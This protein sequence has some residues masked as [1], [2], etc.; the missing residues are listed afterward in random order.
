MKQ[1]FITVSQFNALIADIICCEELLKNCLVQGEVSG[2]MVKDNN[3]YFTLKDAKAALS[4]CCFG[5]AGCYIPKNGEKV[6]VQGS[7]DYY[8]KTGRL[9]LIAYNIEPLG[10]GKLHLQLEALKQK[11]KDEGLF[12]A[13][14]KKEIPK[15][16]KTV[17]VVTSAKGAVIQD[18]ISTIRCVNKLIDITV[19]DVKVQGLNAVQSICCGLQNADMLGLDVV[20]LARGGGSFEELMPFN[21]E[22]VARTIFEMHTP[23]ISAIGHETDVSISD[24]V[25][26]A[27]A[28][29]PTAAAEIVAYNT[30]EIKKGV[31]FKTNRCKNAL[32]NKVANYKN[33]IQTLLNRGFVSIENKSER[34]LNKLPILN[35]A[36]LLKKGYFKVMKGD[37]NINSIKNLSIGDEF[38]LYGADG[39]LKAKVTENG[40]GKQN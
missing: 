15:F 40:F 28:I 4:V 30:S 29:T 21:D 12:S 27:R 25:A 31:I 39:K 38:T 6:L 13:E 32:F 5:V 20:I 9:S 37:K 35:P 19:L 17:G 2:A 3:L 33:K 16:A 10:A 36:E 14:F 11:L 8:Q 7:P 34:L 22:Q 26:D 24:F 1:N 23:I 18:I